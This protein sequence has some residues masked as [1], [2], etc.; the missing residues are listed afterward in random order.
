[1]IKLEP[2]RTLPPCNNCHHLW[3]VDDKSYHKAWMLCQTMLAGMKFSITRVQNS[4]Y[5][6]WRSD[7]KLAAMVFPFSQMKI[8]C[9]MSPIQIKKIYFK[10]ES[11][12]II[13]SLRMVLPFWFI[14]NL[15]ECMAKI[16]ENLWIVVSQ[17]ALQK[18]NPQSRKS[19]ID[20]HH[21]LFKFLAVRHR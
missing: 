9:V 15:S 7:C 8:K 14:L 11:H 16:Q 21:K 17:K 19:N 12:H 13:F 1:M 2:D 18:I 10:W 5:W 20:I 3:R 4:H 6:A